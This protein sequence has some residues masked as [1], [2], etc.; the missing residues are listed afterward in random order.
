MP[1]PPHILIADDTVGVRA[2]IGRI[3]V[4]TYP[5]VTVTAVGNGAEALLA[6]DRHGVDLIITNQSM[7]TLDGL[8]LIRALRA[9][10][11]QAPILMVSADPLLEQAALMAGATRFLAKPFSVAELQAVL[12]AL[13]PM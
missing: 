11:I 1:Q 9:H 2:L 4:R 5:A 3:I 12:L 10:Q 6:L 8:G 7:P 13:R